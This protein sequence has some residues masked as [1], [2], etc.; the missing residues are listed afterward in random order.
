MS[1]FPQKN[2]GGIR[3]I[4][5]TGILISAIAAVILALTGCTATTTT[6][7][8]AVGAAGGAVVG[9]V[10]GRDTKSTMLGAAAGGLAGALAGNMIEQEKRARIKA[11][12]EAEQARQDQAIE[13]SRPRQAATTI[14]SDDNQLDPTIGEI[15]ND[16]R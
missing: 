4:K 11:E 2:S 14:S 6:K 9:Q 15:T 3:K 12:M 10:I 13:R 1:N 8:A 7:G 16:T 5:R